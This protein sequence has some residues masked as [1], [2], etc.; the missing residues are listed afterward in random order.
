MDTNSYDF[1]ALPHTS[2]EIKKN[3]K[4]LETFNIWS[5]KI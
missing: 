1:A 4:Y 2:Q 5:L 3:I